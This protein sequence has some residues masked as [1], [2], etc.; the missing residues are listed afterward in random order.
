MLYNAN[1]FGAQELLPITPFIVQIIPD[2]QLSWS[3]RVVNKY[4][5]V[6]GKCAEMLI[7]VAINYL[8]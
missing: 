8:I 4:K 3:K 5:T 6:S 2:F 1:R 7:F